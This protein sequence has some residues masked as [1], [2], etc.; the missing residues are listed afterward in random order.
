MQ[1]AIG[2]ADLCVKAMEADGCTEQQARDNIWMMDIDGLLTK[3]RTEGNL[4][5]HKV[6]YAKDHKTMKRLI[7]VVQDVKP[8][9]LIGRC[10]FF[11]LFKIIC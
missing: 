5:G 7:D 3:G 10:T 2:I 4:D 11:S 8:T 9:V 1:A 6:W